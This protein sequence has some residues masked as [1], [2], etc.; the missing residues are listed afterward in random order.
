MARP[1]TPRS[2]QPQPQC[3]Q[4]LPIFLSPTFATRFQPSFVLIQWFYID[5]IN[6]RVGLKMELPATENKRRFDSFEQCVQYLVKDSSQPVPMNAKECWTAFSWFNVL[7]FLQRSL[8][9]IPNALLYGVQ[10]QFSLK[11]FLMSIERQ[12]KQQYSFEEPGKKHESIVQLREFFRTRRILT[13]LTGNHSPPS[14]QP[15]PPY[16]NDDWKETADDDA[17]E[18]TDDGKDL[19]K[20]DWKNL[21]TIDNYFM[22]V[23]QRMTTSCQY[24]PTLHGILDWKAESCGGW[25]IVFLC[26]F[27]DARD[28]TTRELRER[29][30][31]YSA[32]QINSVYQKILNEFI[33]N[34]PNITKYVKE[35]TM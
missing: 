34:H 1:L 25:D 30:I 21:E 6:N 12:P 16:S 18:T 15:P 32:L 27:G 24:D 5:Q 13:S 23:T 11:D 20:P 9:D 19:V 10:Y 3:V 17:K 35:S 2:N 14:P 29:W 7:P 33:A 4:D 8:Y 22:N 28:G 26:Q 31:H